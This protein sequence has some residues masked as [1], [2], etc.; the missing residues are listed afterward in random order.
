V[1]TRI[2]SVRLAVITTHPIQ[3][4][5]P[6]FQGLAEGDALDVHVFYGWEGPS[7]GDYDPGFDEEVTW[8]ISLLEGY[9]YTFLE[10][11][12]SDPGTHHFRGILTPG[13]VPAVED[14][15][16][17]AVLL[18]GWNYWGYLGALRHFSGQVPVF[19]RG[20]ST[21]LDEQPGPRRWLRRL[22]LR[23]VYTHVDV[24]L[25]VGQN[26][27]DYFKAHGLSEDQLAWVPHAIDN[28][29]F[30]D[31]GGH[32]EKEARTWRRE[33]GIPNE[34]CAV[35]FAGKLS[36]KKAPDL[37]LEAFCRL[38]DSSA[39]LVVAGSGPLGD[40]LRSDFGDRPRIHFVGFQ[41][42]SRMPVVYRLGEVFVLPSRGP[43]ETW[44]LALNEA[45]AC[46]R[47]VV[48]SDKVGGAPDLIKPG[49]N[50]FVVPAGEVRAL[51]SALRRLVKNDEMR[52]RMGVASRERIRD[53]SV[54][55]ATDRH[56]E[57]VQGYLGRNSGSHQT[58][59][60]G[61]NL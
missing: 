56:E 3:Y 17:D 58:P 29:R 9:P 4:Y 41:N 28:D 12:A 23:W 30:A 51:T 10:N 60:Q 20:D 21:L 59:D 8:D 6:L 13:L 22:F 31:P 7:T 43:G 53:W 61:Q 5:A 55:R 36:E 33:L 2:L 52:R 19:F 39:H 54:V 25:Y 50:G 18:F 40:E 46:G 49:E 57:V 27:R 1:K 45:M 15:G 11:E 35:V 24:A 38:D 47:A 16:P 32:P 44:G 48:A 37:L 42:Q 14:W 26:N 34:A